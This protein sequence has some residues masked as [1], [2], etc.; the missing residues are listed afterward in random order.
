MIKRIV[1][2]GV[3]SALL[4]TSIH[5][6]LNNSVSQGTKPDAVRQETI[7]Q[8]ASQELPKEE[9]KSSQANQQAKPKQGVQQPVAKTVVAKEKKTQGCEQYRKE[10]QK[11]DWNVEIAFAV[12]RAENR[13][14]NPSASNSNTNGSVDRGLFQVNSVHKNKVK[15]LDDLYNPTTNIRVAYSVYQG[16]GWAAWS[17]YKSGRYIAFLE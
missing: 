10:L 2:S 7:E 9:P 11:Y 5:A 3:L 4:L 6:P 17:T 8:I 1:I 15:T 14:C 16:S 12:M 13:A